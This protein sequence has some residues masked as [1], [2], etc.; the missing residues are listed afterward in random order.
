MFA[1]RRG[2]SRP[3]APVIFS[4]PFLLASVI[5]QGG[6][7]VLALDDAEDNLELYLTSVNSQ[8]H[9]QNPNL[10]IHYL[11]ADNLKLLESSQS[12]SMMLQGQDWSTVYIRLLTPENPDEHNTI[13]FQNLTTQSLVTA[14]F[15]PERKTKIIA[16]GFRSKSSNF[17]PMARGMRPVFT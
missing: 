3:L 11:S 8:D 9:L 15:K 4:I 14:G 16:H 7:G 2:S 17:L 12:S 13:S 5:G 1:K 10:M 6:G